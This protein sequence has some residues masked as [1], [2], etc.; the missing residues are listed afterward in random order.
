VVG[1]ATKRNAL[2]EAGIADAGTDE[3]VTRFQTHVS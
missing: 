3:N 2:R 1:D